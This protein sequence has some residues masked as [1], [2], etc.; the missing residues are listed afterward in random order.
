[1]ADEARSA[2][3]MKEVVGAIVCVYQIRGMSRDEQVCTRQGR[4]KMR[5]DGDTNAETSCYMY[6]VLKVQASQ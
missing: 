6:V 2:R 1:M 3:L 5:R 4:M